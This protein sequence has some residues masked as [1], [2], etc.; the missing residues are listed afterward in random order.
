MVRIISLVDVYCDTVRSICKLGYS[1]DNQ[2]VILF[3]VIG[4]NNI[5][6]VSDAEKCC[7]II[8][9]CQ[10]II[11]GNIFLAKLSCHSFQLIHIF[12]IYCRQNFYCSIQPV[13]LFAFGKHFLHNL[14]CKRCPGAILD[15]PYSAVL[16]IMLR[17]AGDVVIHKRI[18]AGIVGSSCKNQL[19][20]AESIRQSQRHIVSCKVINNN[21]RTSLAAQLVGQQ[22]YRFSGVAIYGSIS[23]YN[24]LCFR[25]VRGPG[26]IKTD[27][28]SQILCKNRAVKR[29]DYLN[30]QSSGNF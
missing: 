21:L 10:L 2:S 8:F 27:I 3:A 15:Q 29:T 24:T 28:M 14:C 1:V 17:Q 23:N 9:I 26:I 20:V 25:S 11:L 6:T 18:N 13:D 22:I 30:I 5:K 12:L 4:G 19:A 16:E 7:H